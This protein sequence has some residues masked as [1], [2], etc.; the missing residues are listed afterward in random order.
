MREISSPFLKVH[1][2]RKEVENM[3]NRE[4]DRDK[5]ER[6]AYE[7][8]QRQVRKRFILLVISCICV[9]II[10]EAAVF[11]FLV[12]DEDM[13]LPED[14][15]IETI[16][17]TEQKIKPTEEPLTETLVENESDD[18]KQLRWL[19]E[20]VEHMDTSIYMLETVEVLQQ[21]CREAQAV[22][23]ASESTGEDIEMACVNLLLATQQLKLAK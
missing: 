13:E 6:L 2:Y 5:K 11:Y 4:T 12:R 21:R 9:I 23:N 16:A 19:L 14:I 17:D 3:V 7:K 15:Q 22:L 1:F 20:K 18:L 8:R 10:L